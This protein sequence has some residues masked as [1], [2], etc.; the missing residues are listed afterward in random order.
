ML[1]VNKSLSVSKVSTEEIGFQQVIKFLSSIERNSLKSRHAYQY[2]LISFQRFLSQKYPDYNLETILKPLA[3]NKINPYEL[4]D[5][6]VSYFQTFNATLTPTT[7]RLYIASV[8]SYFAYNDIDVIPSKFKRKVKMPKSYREDEEPLDASDIRKISLA[9]NNRRLKTYLLILASGGMR[10][11]EGLAIRI[12]DIDFSVNPTKIRIRKEYTKTRV[13][14]DIYISNEA[15][16]YLKQWFD[17]KY[18]NPERPRRQDENDLVFTIFRNKNPNTLY[19]KVLKEFHKLLA[20]VGLNER[21]EGGKQRRRKI[22]LHS[23]RRFT[24]S[25][26]S[27]QVGQDFSEWFLGHSKSPY[28]TKKEPERREIYAS[29]CM[30]YLTFLDYTTLEARGRSIEANLREKDT[31]IAGLKE[32]YDTDI[33]LLKDQMRDMQQLLKNPEKLA[34]ISRAAKPEF[35]R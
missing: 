21:K 24:K 25:V 19:V 35:I 10:A 2:G 15:T 28:Y 32:K 9:C 29:K 7:I 16:H 3:E 18:N 1:Y 34:E 12:K 31:E 17:W 11:V 20:I 4:L 27:D 33:A 26:I 14:R 22:T 13:S 30:K 5:S 6:F 8:R 23:F